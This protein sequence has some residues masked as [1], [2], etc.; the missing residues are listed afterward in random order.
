MVKLS[1]YISFLA[2]K[3]KYVNQDVR[4]IMNLFYKFESNRLKKII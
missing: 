1:S 3:P 2:I 4:K